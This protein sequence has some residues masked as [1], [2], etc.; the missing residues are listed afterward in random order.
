MLVS[1]IITR[2]RRSVGDIDAL[3]VTDED[4]YRWINDAMREVAANNQLLQIKASTQTA[5][6]TSGYNL[7][8]DILKLHS[9][10][11]DKTKLRVVTLKEAEDT[12]DVGN[13][14]TGTPQVCYIWANKFELVPTPNAA[15]TLD[16][17]YTRQPTDVTASGDTPEIPSQYHQR[18]VDYCKAQVAEMDDDMDRYSVKMN[19]FRTGV[20]NLKDHPEWEHEMYP[21]I[22]VS[23][24]DMGV[25][26]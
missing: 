12:Y 9:V 25:F 19:E 6:G 2:V 26:E 21:S 20:Q 13:V 7:P 22:T 5:S 16:F 3:Q 17:F 10:R 8:T 23:D 15:K 24:R 18:L 4:I 11:Y 14:S 1:D